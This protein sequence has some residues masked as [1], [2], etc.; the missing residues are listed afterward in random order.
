LRLQFSTWRT[1]KEVMDQVRQTFWAKIIVAYFF[2]PVHFKF[3]LF[4]TYKQTLLIFKGK[5]M[6][7]YIKNK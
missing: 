6:I 5:C 3:I 2:Q 4:Q 1:F 7:V